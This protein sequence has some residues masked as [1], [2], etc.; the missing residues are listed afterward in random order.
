M[1]WSIVKGL[2]KNVLGN[3][4]SLWVFGALFIWGLTAAYNW[5]QDYDGKITARANA[6]HTQAELER[7]QQA[8]DIYSKEVSKM[9][10]N[11]VKDEKAIAELKT[12]SESQE[13]LINEALRT[14]NQTGGNWATSTVP[15]NRQ[16]VLSLTIQE[17]EASTDLSTDSEGIATGRTTPKVSN[18]FLRKLKE[19]T[20]RR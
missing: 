11:R 15:T 7:A 2:F 1:I 18:D 17:L 8:R 4:A 14:L 3:Q 20:T 13:A 12:F 5:K 6:V 9:M 19:A 16:R 10:D